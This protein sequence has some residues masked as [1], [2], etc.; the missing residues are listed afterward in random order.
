[1]ISE[2]TKEKIN[3]DFKNIENLINDNDHRVR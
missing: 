3:Y 2:E 1:M